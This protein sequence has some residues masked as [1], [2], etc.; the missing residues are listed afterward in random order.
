MPLP[1]D[2]N[3]EIIASKINVSVRTVEGYQEEVGRQ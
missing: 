2:L 3:Y 1:S